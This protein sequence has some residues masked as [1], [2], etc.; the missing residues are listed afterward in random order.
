MAVKK[1][2]VKMYRAI[3]VCKI[4]LL[5]Q[6]KHSENIIYGGPVEEHNNMDRLFG[7]SPLESI[8][9]PVCCY[10]NLG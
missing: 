10:L 2:R 9:A 4:I 8:Q 1:S 7:V 5:R 6:E 3:K